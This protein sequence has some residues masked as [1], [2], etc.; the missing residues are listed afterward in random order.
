MY[1]AFR[2]IDKKPGED[3]KIF[4]ARKEKVERGIK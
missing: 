1:T 2:E 4:K 3:D